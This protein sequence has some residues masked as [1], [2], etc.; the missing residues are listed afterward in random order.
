M[1]KRILLFIIFIIILTKNILAVDLTLTRIVPKGDYDNGD[2]V[3]YQIV[4]VN[5]TDKIV[6]GT[7]TFPIGDLVSN[8]DGG[9]TGATFT[10]IQNS[11]TVVGDK[12]DT[13]NFNIT[14]N[15]NARGLVIDAKGKITYTIKATIN[16]DVNGIISPVATFTD[17]EGQ[18]VTQANTM[19]RVAYDISVNKVSRL[20]YYEKG[21]Q[22][23][24][25]ITI[26][27]RGTSSVK[28]LNVTDIL[29]VNA[30][31]SAN[32]VATST[33][34]GTNPGI[35]SQ[36]GNLVATGAYIAL[37]GS[38]KY[39]ITGQLNPDFV[40]EL[41]NSVSVT[42]R[43]ETK[44]YSSNP[45]NLPNYNYTFQKTSAN[46]NG[47][48]VPGGLVT[49][50]LTISNT[51]ATIPI[52]N[53][54]LIDSLSNV[55]ALDTN[56]NLVPALDTSRITILGSAGTANSS[57]GNF[58]S[59]SEPN[60]TNIAIAPN[61]KVTYIVRTFVKPNIVGKITNTATITDRNGATLSRS[62]AGLNSASSNITLTKTALSTNLFI[63][64]SP[65]KYLVNVKNIGQGIGYG[66]NVVDNI[67]D[68]TSSLANS[69]DVSALD[70]SG[71]PAATWS[72]IASLGANSTKSTS[73]LLQNGGTI[74]NM[75]LND[76]GVTIYPG[77]EINYEVT[78]NTKNT[79]I[80][81]IENIAQGVGKTAAA[82]YMPQETITTD[83][84]SIKITKSS[85]QAE[86]VPG[87]KIT[88]NI[89]ATNLDTKFANNVSI[90]D[91]LSNIEALNTSGINSKV[92]KDWT[93]NFVSKS[94]NGTA[95]GDFNYGATNPGAQDLNI[96]ADIGPG[97][98]IIYELV[99]T[100]NPDI[101]GKIF[102][103]NL[104]G[105]VVE[106]GN[107]I[108]MAP[109]KLELQKE[110]NETEYTP[111]KQVE[112]TINITNSGNGT[113]VNIPVIDNFSNI[114]TQLVTGVLGNAYQSTSVT[115]TVYNSDGSV[116]TSGP[117]NPG[118]T[119]TLVDENLNVKATISPGKRIQYKIVA[120]I[121]SL[122]EGRIINTA[123]VNTV[124]T[125]D[126]GI[127]TRETNV[128]I[129]KSV[130]K[131]SYPNN[132][133]SNGEVTG[134][135]IITY[136]ITVAN[137]SESGIA[138]NI[139]VKD[140][141][142]TITAELLSGGQAPVFKPGWTI[143]TTLT[144]VGTEISGN[145]VED[146]KDID[147]R[148]N[149]G[150][151]GSAVFT[152]RGTVN[153]TG[154]QIFYGAFTNSAGDGQIS[155]SASTVPKLPFLRIAKS[156]SNTSYT[157]GGEI[158]YVIKVENI[159][160]GFANDA[161]ITDLLDSVVD[162]AGKKA[163]S[164]WSITGQG[165]GYGTTVG[166]LVDN[167]NIDTTVDIAPGGSV[168]YTITGKLNTGLTGIITNEVQVYDPQN[169]NTSTA[170][171]SMDNID[172]D[173]TIFIRKTSNIP[174]ISPMH[175]FIYYVE[176]LN[177]SK[178]QIKDITIADDLN[179]IT[180]KLANL[181]GSTTTDVEG[182]AFLSWDIYRNNVKINTGPNDSLND[183]INTLVPQ[184][185]VRYRIEATPNPKLLPQKLKNIADV[186]S[187]GNKIAS[188]YIENNVVGSSGGITRSVNLSRYI[189][190]DTLTYTI[191]I[192]P[193][194]VGYLNNFSV[195]E[196]IN[197]L[198]VSLMNGNSGNVF[199]NPNTGKNEFT[200]E[201][202][203]NQSKVSPGTV[204]IPLSDIKNN[205]NLTGV[206]DVA[207]GDY[208]VYKISGK[209]R[210]DILG[211]INYKG[212]VT[213]FYRQN[214]TIT[215]QVVG[216]NYFPGEPLKYILKVENNSKGNAGQV[217]LT[218]NLAGIRVT[219][220]KG[221]LIPAFV[222]DTI[223]VDSIKE[224]GYAASA[225]PI[226]DPKNIDVKIDVPIGGYIEYEITGEVADTAVGQIINI[227]KVGED[228]VSTGASA[229][230]NRFV[231]TKTMDRYLDVDGSTVLTAGY[232]PGGY[233]QY[234]INIANQNDGIINDYP[235]TDL[236]GDITTAL[237][238][239]GTG[240]A[241]TSWTISAEKDSS[242]ATDFGTFS[243]NTNLNTTVD[244]GPNGYIKYTILAKVNPL[245]VGNFTN[246]V[247]ING[248]VRTSALAQMAPEVIVHTKKVYDSTGTTEI[249]N[250]SPGDT[251]VYKI[252]IEN[253][254][255]GTSYGKGYSDLLSQILANEAGNDITQVNPFGNKWTIAASTVG[256]ITTLGSYIPT[257]NQDIK[258]NNMIIAPGGSVTFTVTA[259]IGKKIF[260][261]IQNI[262][263]YD[264]N[265][266]S[267]ILKP[268]SGNLVATNIVKTL[269][270][271]SFTPTSKYKPGDSVTYEL[272][273]TNTGKG[274]LD[275]VTI[276]DN[277]LNIITE[278]SGE[279]GLLQALENIVIGNPVINGSETFITPL[280]ADSSTAVR[281]SAD[282]APGQ[283]ITINISG[284]ISKKALG[285]ISE[286]ILTVNGNNI[287]SSA[288][289]PEPPVLSGSKVL[290]TPANKIYTPG[291]KISYRLTLENKGLGY[292]NNIVLR[293]LIGNITTETVGRKQGPAFASWEIN[294]SITGGEYAQY[295]ALGGSVNGPDGLDTTIDI[296]PGV[297]LT[298]DIV[299]T[300]A[301]NIV[302]N[303]VN[304]ATLGTENYSAQAVTLK[305]ADIKEI[306]VSKIATTPT[307]APDKNIGFQIIVENNSDTTINNLLL[308]DLIGDITT[309]QAGG[310]PQDKAFKSGWTITTTM[311]GDSENSAV[312]VPS[313]GNL[314]DSEIDLASKTQVTIDI[315]G[316]A[317]SKSLGVIKNMANWSYNGSSYST[318]EV[319]I[320]PKVGAVKITKTANV[321]QYIP[322]DTLEYTLQVTNV[323]NGYIN[324]GQIID[325]L[326]GVEV[327]LIDS[328]VKG[329]AFGTIKLISQEAS[330]Q[331]SKL[332]TPIM[333]D[334][335]LQNNA[336][337]YPGDTVTV[338]LT[339]Q[340]NPDAYGPITNSA[341]AIGG[342]NADS[343][344]ITL[345]SVPG[346]LSANKSVD[347]L[348]YI[349]G[350]TLTYKIN[351]TNSGQGWLKGVSVKD[352][353]S[354]INTEFVDGTTGP[355]FETFAD[356][357][358]T[359]NIGPN[360]TE[361][362]T[363][364]G[365]LKPNT[366]GTIT[367]SAVVN[368]TS[369]NEVVS[370]P[371]IT[372][373]DLSITSDSFYI[374]GNGSEPDKKNIVNYTVTLTNVGDAAASIILNDPIL[375]IT[376]K[377]N[378]Q[379]KIKAFTKY[380]V[381]SISYPDG[382]NLVLNVPLNTDIS[383][384]EINVSGNLKSKGVLTFTIEA[385]LNETTLEA[386]LGSI[387]NTA[388]VTQNTK[389]NSASVVV[390]PA[391]GKP[392]VTKTIKSIGGKAYTEGMG[393]SPK[394]EL[395]Y[396]IV[397]INAGDGYLENM[398]LLDNIDFL[399]I[400]L[401]GD[402]TGNAFS[403]YGWTVSS[404]STRTVVKTGDFKD[405]TS[406]NTLITLAPQ[407][408]VTIT[409]KGTISDKAV[410]TIPSNTVNFG[411][412]IT[413]TS[414]I[415]SNSGK[416][417]ITKKVTSNSTYVPGGT[418][419]YEV[420]LKN[421]GTGYLDDVTIKDTLDA[422]TASGVGVKDAKV[423]SNWTVSISNPGTGIIHYE[424][425]Y[426]N[427]EN[428][429]DTLDIAPGASA[430]FTIT[431]QVNS[432]IYGEIENSAVA[433]YGGDSKTAT[434]STKSDPAVVTLTK[435]PINPTYSPGENAGF[436][437]SITN[438]SNAIAAGIAIED[439]VENMRVKTVDGTDKFP[440]KP[441]YTISTS[442]VGDPSNTRLNIP[443]SGNI[444]VTG[445][446]APKTTY[447]I[448]ISGTVIDDAVESIENT[449]SLTYN[450]VTTS[451]IAKIGPNT[452]T[453]A[454]EK[455]ATT[456]EFTPG[457]ILTYNIAV[458]NSGVG[459][460][461]GAQIQDD[462]TLSGAFDISTI[463]TN[464]TAGALSKVY[465]LEVKNGVLTAKADIHPGETVN[466]QV[467]AK[468]LET[469]I[470]PI[471][472]TAI[473]SYLGNNTNSTL[474]LNSVPGALSIEKTQSSKFYGPGAQLYYTLTVTNKGD[475]WLK[476][477]SIYDDVLNIQTQILGGGQGPAFKA[478]TLGASILS[479][480][481]STLQIVSG[482]NL[483]VKGDI[484]PQT[485]A[486]IVIGGNVSD[487]AV[488]VIQNT[489]RAIQNNVTYPSE[490]VTSTQLIPQLVL[491]K[492]A[493]SI[494]YE[495]G[496]PINYTITV[497]NNSLNNAPGIKLTDF[498]SKVTVLDS[499]KQTVPAF[500]PGWT[501]SYSSLDP[502]TSITGTAENAKDI[503][504]TMGIR[505]YD[506][507][508]FKI[509]GE[510]IDNA[511]GNIKNIVNASD[512]NNNSY[513]SFYE[514]IPK[515]PEI[516][517]TKTSQLEK[518]VPG[519]ILTYDIVVK[520]LGAGF[521]DDIAVQDILSSIT[522]DTPT[523][524][525][526][527]F[528][529][530]TATIKIKDIS[531][532]VVTTLGNETSSS[533][534]IDTLDM[535]PN[536]SIT[537]EV[538]AV[539]ASDAI[540]AITNTA[541]AQ[542][543][544][545][546]ST[547]L[548]ENYK[549]DVSMD[550]NKTVYIPGQDVQFDL[551][552]KNI[553]LGYAY[554]IDVT[555]LI[556][557]LMAEGV[558]GD[559]LNC[560][561]SW[562]VIKNGTET[563]N[564]DIKEVINIAPK[565][566]V[567]YSVIATVD[568][569]LSG[570][571]VINSVVEDPVNQENF[572]NSVKFTPPE[573]VLYLTKTSDKDSYGDEDKEIIYTLTLENKGIGNINGVQVKDI[574]TDLKGKN[575]NPLFTD[576]KVK[577]KEEGVSANETIPVKDNQNI[578]NSL[579][580]RS[581]GQN[582]IVYEIIGNINKGIDD[583]ITNTFIAT[584]PFTGK[585]DTASV[586]N[587]IKKIPDNEGELK[588]I[589]RAL[590]R[591]IKVGE[592]AEYEIIVENNNE[593]RFINIALKDL[594]PSGFKYI[595]GTTEITESG[596]DG[597]LNT[598]DD[599]VRKEEPI[600]G[601]GLNF[602]SFTMEPFTKYRV[603]YLLKPSIGV[604]FGKY[605]NQ[606]YV[607]LNGEKISNTAT[608]T[609]SI[610]GD[611]LLDTASII[612]KV[613][614]DENAN[615]YQ[616]TGEKGIPGVRL[617]T[618]TGIV[619]ITDRFGRY[620]V[621]DEWVYSRMG[622]NY[623]IKLDTTT[624]PENVEVLSEN[625]Q[626]KRIT[627]QGLS[628]FN[629]SV[630]GIPG[631][632]IE[633]KNRIY[634]KDGAIWVVNDSIEIEPEL[635]LTLPERAVVKNG[636][637]TED[638]DFTIKTNYGDFITKYEI[639]IYSQEDN[640]L[641]SPI[642]VL[643][644][645]K[646][647]NDMK[648]KWDGKDSQ[649]LNLKIGNQLKVR[650]KVWNKEKQFDT[651]ELGYI[652]L[653][654]RKPIVDLFNYKNKNE[655][656][657][658]T[659]NIPLNTGMAR[660]TG[661]G[662][663]NI[664]K[665]Y[666]GEDEYDV[667]QDNFVIS[668]YMPSA[669]Y[670]MPIKLVNK[671]GEESDYSLKVDLPETYYMGTGIADFSIGRNYVSGN[672]E[673]LNADNP[674]G[675]E[676]FA[677]NIYNEGRIA[678]YGRG[679]YKDKL[680]FT[681]HIDTKANSVNEM[682]DNILKRDKQTLFER[683]EDNDY[684]YYPTYGDKSYVYKDAETDGKIYLKLQY[685]KSSIMWG[686][687]NTGFTGSKYMQYNRSLYGAKGSYIS[688][689]TT[690]FGDDKNVLTGFISEPDSLFGHDEFLGTG[691][692]LY[693]LKN[694]DVLNGTEKVWIK[695]VDSNTNLTEKIIYLQAGKDYEFDP[696]QGR[697]ILNRPLNGTVSNISGDI[698]QGSPSGNYYSYLVVDY[699]YVPTNSQNIDE[700]DYGFRGRTF[701][702]DHLGVGGTFIQENKTGKNYTLTGGEVILK[703]TENTYF[704]GEVSRSEGLQSDNS[705]ISL[706]GGL[707]FKKISGNNENISGNAY[708]FTGVLNLADLNPNVFSPYG[709]DIRTWYEE[710]E[711][712]YSFA[713]D[714]GD[715]YLKSYGG[716]INL[717]NSDRIKS[718]FKYESME[719]R[720]Y[721][722]TLT[723]KKESTGIQMEYLLSDR[724]STAGA[725]EHVEELKNGEIGKGDLVGARVEYEIDENTKVF[726]E[727]QL[728]VNKSSNYET[729]NIITV[730][731]E[732]AVTEKVTVN[733][734]TSVGTRGNYT[735]IGTDYNVTDDYTV[736]M[737]YSMDGEENTNKITGGQRAR[738][739]DKINVYQ[740]NQFL[741]ESGR[742]GTTQSYGID[743]E[744]VEDVTFGGSFQLGKIDLPDE[745]GTSKRKGVS[746]YSRV[747]QA[748]FMLKNKIEY[749]EDK[750]QN[751]V[752]QYLTT[753]TFNYVYSDEYTFAGK[754]NFAFTDDVENTKFIESSIGLAYRPVKN[755]KLNFLS[756]YTV[757]LNDEPRD[758][759]K[760]KAYI[761]EFESIYSYTPKLDL[762]LKTA[763]R[764][765]QDTYLR[766]SQNSIIVNNNL[767][768]VGLKANYA[769][770][771]SWDIYGQYHWLV[772]EREKDVASGA[773]I[774]I[775]KNIHRN[776]KFG[777]GYNFS[778]FSDN[779]NVDD[780]R[781]HGWFI[782]AIGR[783]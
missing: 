26:T 147:T 39:T 600:M 194:S 220:S 217:S 412:I 750:T 149:V 352:T 317:S 229:P 551:I 473:L 476:G 780:Y 84:T 742:N 564:S 738:M 71:S 396:E 211:D 367:N 521:G 125:S 78:I 763:Y 80:G 486:T 754:V 467:Q 760:S 475:G 589:K 565:G 340:V 357:D 62:D 489:A 190:G 680:R 23:T 583:T 277:F 42:T 65:V 233:I 627:P 406:L 348:N 271:Q 472:N 227:L 173:G 681:A 353:L 388:T 107:G 114:R 538:S 299:G 109:Y 137:G 384:R 9:G 559:N 670:D 143:E 526:N 426:P 553:G 192:A 250:Y 171:A 304:T 697:I 79:A 57:I 285:T 385:E 169:I 465:A 145:P 629:F 341:Q 488:G 510:V 479:Q 407:S 490:T 567:T 12:T 601:N 231:A 620:H 728:T 408:T 654:S 56:G 676:Y 588:V 393:Y 603:R 419:V 163:L 262:S 638:L 537:Y 767:Y 663:K 729:N 342:A 51:S 511:V 651:T 736:Y 777:G 332:G 309:E 753:N 282:I 405:N 83:S 599:I 138:M 351:L 721:L 566:V 206:V 635:I 187:G 197:D 372:D 119:G 90:T 746:L 414:S 364:I 221:N 747:E 222:S 148:V 458:K 374:T 416:I 483:L 502:L 286:N 5:N 611:A 575:G 212:L 394:D 303:V 126:K 172:E 702:N 432:N 443:T 662:L 749:R 716:E 399:S 444:N 783:F 395:I 557:T 550:Q 719:K 313:S 195:D 365:K 198:N 420:E 176:V 6:S 397:L 174:A 423:F 310:G 765:E 436:V 179:Q 15:L 460:A 307:Y 691:G 660:F 427:I 236:I 687:Y 281:K 318:P 692:S 402:N 415:P 590:K 354:T 22:V 118:F 28:N 425:T 240:K 276:R 214:L 401:V 572:K 328:E 131:T 43:Q 609:V 334:G 463:S 110:V 733:G 94:G 625:P 21:G 3:E 596:A 129:S 8:L 554:N 398:S 773:I 648:V 656:L 302:G 76:T 67:G 644:G 492:V 327:D 507:V 389:V 665:I 756:R 133:G 213:T 238:T 180:G 359:I 381:T 93:L 202:V 524:T 52:T 622:E 579:N 201:F 241:F 411:G 708:N 462:L 17:I 720:D 92:V 345:S 103:S 657:L 640:L 453:L 188:S 278:K 437:V 706:D 234:T 308:T 530:S 536:S 619:A 235:V 7:L 284:N 769:I 177:N 649:N 153:N 544:P 117:D 555:E 410:G 19:N 30:F 438:S 653:V 594:I 54:S 404:S 186:Y 707:N 35:Y 358:E 272:T 403:N 504:V 300:L 293:D 748:D 737:G 664:D 610:I 447:N 531:Q 225:P 249:S 480:G 450:S 766:E 128:S 116:S 226:S 584:N 31:K 481:L 157:D 469:R 259:T 379:N 386:P 68:I 496:K 597:V 160:Y 74:N 89:V 727:G 360:S 650:L 152:V 115:A 106:T 642:K 135:E 370:N 684:A 505:A 615:G 520:N 369:T 47:Q 778:G 682:F 534:L 677:D 72:V 290:V 595:K 491:R 693:F 587:Y 156:S 230:Q 418:I 181:D 570:N 1:K 690:K 661:D 666:I 433:T 683:V 329:P 500:K 474:T 295:T 545:A 260:G 451:K 66:L 223:K 185:G 673:V 275:N 717:R 770:L 127:V 614:Y 112:Y 446:L 10:N 2:G 245:A 636:N 424:D 373:L 105:N 705:F 522:V 335:Y 189:P 774:G 182:K 343:T 602:P 633:D 632:K 516:N 377:S 761:V 468:V 48:Y 287:L 200:V 413:K 333:T 637:L 464:V 320:T 699:E 146:G 671:N 703:A 306:S 123:L 710:K 87:G 431:A 532:G 13:G 752:R 409:L 630:R 528:D 757:I 69:G 184:E 618:P 73:A 321:A 263:T 529:M 296:G 577:V 53:M 429:D 24:Y 336:D 744:L 628:K 337:I 368:G 81:T 390:E 586:T 621:P 696:Y 356:I 387:L 25:D 593:S 435:T 38:L 782:N 209:I 49:Y 514:S 312:L 158:N 608:A 311:I 346:E 247:N 280:A 121:N 591:D 159:G 574:I 204:P 268:Y 499:N 580:L 46:A 205:N 91:D 55:T 694:G 344:S 85:N 449:A 679:K 541:L 428:L 498:I 392:N 731:G 685:E 569:E 646:I 641:S 581:E 643:S 607:T 338:K 32:I 513:T 330:S 139:P 215:K 166:N 165:T 421:T 576:W 40:G 270:N 606:A 669:Q 456:T 442:I 700:K 155:S 239:G 41:A 37:N 101:V 257:D 183:Q 264:Q 100:I 27:N 136:T 543:I 256:D 674:F 612:G 168:T 775:Y 535:P 113:A 323:G 14:G 298:V 242:T 561:T 75:N 36:I 162:G 678:Y 33:G 161:K 297:M 515:D 59:N 686:N 709:N 726:T 248:V 771:N 578:T 98:E 326:L 314:I 542:G 623:E 558:S 487:N 616:D 178:N 560:F 382:D 582:K 512:P 452:G 624:L 301:E 380:R 434:V 634:L 44:S 191:K 768:L 104:T 546:V 617:I 266:Q 122:A 34:V 675:P 723:D 659:Q 493:D 739:T 592:A 517:I 97:G 253:V 349:D 383:D 325:N 366:V 477:V 60:I 647:Y 568:K 549:L 64:G 350:D 237:A 459:Y 111:G 289:N 445:D 61:D 141:I 20:P 50:T 655:V 134:D 745:D 269:N 232:V 216:G 316:T 533:D 506:T 668:R 132:L 254:G 466:I 509:T 688:N 645:D 556:K 626:V 331:N 203:Q 292:G 478:N 86:Y 228:T 196:N 288:I 781:S 724:V 243:D 441:G 361:T 261:N 704:K 701:I 208:L 193:N 273:F 164:S 527:A 759:D 518:Y 501:V 16:P 539:V 598:G 585:I 503:D 120:T 672:Q 454:I 339:A 319:E 18:I 772:D 82:T 417:E 315:L 274:F 224:V 130:D 573:P 265:M 658:Q 695:I 713:S 167:Q 604:T 210:P 251:I 508:T 170:S 440:F 422:I 734:K 151:G 267:V 495:V 548:S 199:Y 563:E 391:Q 347:K 471:T 140:S 725:F 689:G 324:D 631:K 142:S 613:F 571:I 525:T 448:K 605:K 755:D 58:S 732:T 722:N 99:I 562:K 291:S 218:D 743:Y 244:I 519:E 102:D 461:I 698:I 378:L 540:G 322:G 457:K 363:A 11:A 279:T 154:T 207:Q 485:T 639:Q 29:D 455:T 494:E 779:L 77:E 376:T 144:G 294:Y 552:I 375:N 751:K 252:K 246:S 762:G 4:L 430:I 63:P 108:S 255:K 776:L 482:S 667:N 258:S 88:Y 45:I 305:P 355:A 439:A 497:I 718:K 362:V 741:K 470:E 484:A 758:S 735:E 150:P 547:V 283:S 730:G 711:S 70:I 764:R 652:D 523:G 712:G 714:L 219:N 175:K 371:L 96:V 740:E 124:L 95:Q 400:E 715:K